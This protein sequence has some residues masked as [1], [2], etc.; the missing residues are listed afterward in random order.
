MMTKIF[1]ALLILIGAVLLGGGGYLAS[2]GGSLYYLITGAAV[3]ASGVL[4]WRGS[5]SGEQLYALMLIGTLI[6]ACVEAGSDPWALNARL[7]APAVLGLLLALP[8]VRRGLR[9]VTSPAMWRSEA[10]IVAVITIALIGVRFMQ[11]EHEAA[12]VDA[13]PSPVAADAAPAPVDTE[14]ANY[15]NGITGQHF[16]PLTQINAQNVDK[17]KVAWVHHTGD[18][19]KSNVVEATPIKVGD[20]LYTCGAKTQVY[21]IDAKTGKEKWRNDPKGDI[22]KFILATCRGVSFYHVPEGTGVCTDRVIAAGPN[23]MLRALDAETGTPCPDFGTNGVVDLYKDLGDVGPGEYTPNSAPTVAGG[24]I[25]TGAQVGDNFRK[26]IA[27]G[28]IRAFDAKTG[29]LRWAWDLAVPDRVGAPPEG[30]TYTRSTPNAWAAFVVDEALGLVYVPTGNP[31]IDY[32]DT[33]R[34]PFDEKYGSSINALN[35]SDGRVKWTYQTTYHDIWDYDL[36]AQPLLVDLPGPDGTRPAILQATKRGDIFVLDRRDGSEIVPAPEFKVPAGGLAGPARSPVQRFSNLNFIPPPLQEKQMWGA[37]PIDQMICRIHFK[38]ARYDG[39]FTPP[40]TDYSLIYPG[41]GGGTDWGGISVDDDAKTV[42]ANT[43]DVPMF[44]QQVPRE[45]VPGAD[46]TLWPQRQTPY[47]M[48]FGI[49]F[50]PTGIPCNQPPWGKLAAVDIATGKEK[51]RSVVGTAQDDGPFKIATGLKL[52]IGTPSFGGTLT[53]RGNLVFMAATLD[54]YFRAF[55]SK[56]GRMLWEFRIP[57]GGQA[58]PMTYMAGGKQYIVLTTG[59]HAHFGTKPG[60]ETIAF[61]L[62]D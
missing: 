10:A 38:R 49:M 5:R 46:D 42:I 30:E 36:P 1:S 17:L 45:K 14:W 15:G 60:D 25:I 47:V 43:N 48:K 3:I 39:P 29:E 2:L 21:A 50:G 4:Y 18:V 23:N 33:Y 53:T 58:T 11:H 56:T 27:S 24:M 35:L 13:P 59:G 57:A 16:A 61:T 52:L 26:D 32:F 51:W 41:T 22:S 12:K 40:G 6:W 9:G 20:T 44:V 55:D 34:R 19:S 28:V 54:R 31:S 8:W 62:P 7:F 37:T